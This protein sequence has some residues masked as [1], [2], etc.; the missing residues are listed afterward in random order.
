VGS[1]RKKAFSRQPLAIISHLTGTS[2]GSPAEAVKFYLMAD[3]SGKI[4]VRLYAP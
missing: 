4:V 2:D 1:V 3:G